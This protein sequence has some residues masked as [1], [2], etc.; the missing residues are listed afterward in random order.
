MSDNAATGTDRRDDLVYG[1]ICPVCDEEF[2]DGYDEL[3]ENESY[4]A[5]ICVDEIDGNGEG[6]MLVHLT[7]DKT[8]TE[9]ERSA[10]EEHIDDGEGSA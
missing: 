9:T 4:E 2:I 3:E 10:G 1:G 6:K 5:R 8:S 7:G